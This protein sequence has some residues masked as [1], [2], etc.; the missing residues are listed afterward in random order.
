M[1]VVRPVT[2]F[3]I[4]QPW[5]QIPDA[6][7]GVRN[8]DG[9]GGH[10]GVDYGCPNGTQVLALTDGVVIYAGPAS[11]FGDHLVSIWH[12]AYG[13]T[14]RY[15]HMQAHLVNTGD[16]VCAGQPIGVSNNEGDSSGPH[17]HL[18]LGVGQLIDAG[19]P[20][21]IDPEAWLIA[22]LGSAPPVPAPAGGDNPL[23]A[24]PTVNTNAALNMQAPI[25]RTLQGLLEARGGMI[26]PDNVSHPVLSANVKWFQQQA[27]LAVDGVVA[28]A[29]WNALSDSLSG[30]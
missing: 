28:K 12:A 22:H 23:N 16:K 25:I 14:S 21:N 3:T 2:G 11:G 15:G 9:A 8:W 24:L 17:L 18:E 4:T 27:K 10:P 6:A 20:P 13:L 1:T 29:T 30:R 26:K 5:G 7:W 19:N